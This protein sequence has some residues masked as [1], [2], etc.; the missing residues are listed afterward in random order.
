MIAV[1]GATGQTGS[2]TV[3]ELIALGE[4]PLCIVRNAD[5]ARSVL[6]VHAN[7]AVAEITDKPALTKALAGIKRL[8]MVTGHNPQ[9]G[10]QQIGILEAAEAAGVEFVVK[11]SGG[12]DI[13]GPNAESVVGRGHHAVEERMKRGKFAWCVL[14]PGLFM[15]NMLGQA[16]SIKGDSK[17]VQPYAKDFPL[18]FVDVRDTAA[19]GARVLRDPKKHAGKVYTFTGPATN[20]ENF[21]KDFSA[22]LGKPVTYVGVTI[23]QSEAAMKARNMPDWLVAHLVAIARA[24]NKGAFSKENT[25]TVR[26]IVGRAPY[27]TRQFVEAYKGAFV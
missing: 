15:Q 4:S 8:F 12:R 13:V 6:G 5:K 25:Q 18:A 14:S 10:E 9:S 11:V 26:D 22:V 3:K 16:A 2:A 1:I 19:V 7:T 17:I 27:T 24:G 23:E 21:A 20:F